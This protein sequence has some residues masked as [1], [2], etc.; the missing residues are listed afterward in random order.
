MEVET[1]VSVC[2]VLTKEFSRFVE[3]FS[4]F[5]GVKEI[6]LTKD[7]PR[8]TSNG[9]TSTKGPEGD[10]SRSVCGSLGISEDSTVGVQQKLIIMLNC[11]I[12]AS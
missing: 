4:R 12:S 2:A 11:N 3:D 8:S 6:D 7:L 9:V 1:R 10:F 5:A